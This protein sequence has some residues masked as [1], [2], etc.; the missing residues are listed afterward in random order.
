MVTVT[1]DLYIYNDRAHD[2]T[3]HHTRSLTVTGGHTPQQAP[4]L[5]ALLAPVV[6][7]L[8]VVP[9]WVVVERTLAHCCMK[10]STVL[11][12][13]GSLSRRPISAFRKRPALFSISFARPSSSHGSGISP[14]I[15]ATT[16]AQA[17]GSH[18]GYALTA[19]PARALEYRSESFDAQSPWA[20]G[21][22][23]RAGKHRYCCSNA[24]VYGVTATPVWCVTV[25]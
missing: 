2:K 17:Y 19:L 6:L 1:R 22:L 25:A 23:N 7:S 4:V 9:C 10:V 5:E 21:L 16:C 3:A 24:A 12:F 18:V 20:E 8:A 11:R 15:C 13:S 14:R